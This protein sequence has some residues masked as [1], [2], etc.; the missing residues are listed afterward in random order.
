M[1]TSLSIL[2]IYVAL[3]AT[4]SAQE[5]A[6]SV[7]TSGAGELN[8]ASEAMIAPGGRNISIR[9]P[10]TVKNGEVI[11]IQ[12]QSSGN[13]VTDSFMVTGITIRNGTCS[14]ESKHNLTVGTALSDMIYT[15]PCKKLE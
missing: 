12:Y 14:L 13:T 6:A 15:R 11:S 8:R 2:A 1:K 3:T 4:A 5:S 10:A 9:L 7:Q